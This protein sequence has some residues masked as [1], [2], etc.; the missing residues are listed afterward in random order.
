MLR[1][2]AG[3]EAEEHGG[4]EEEELEEERLLSDRSTG[5]SWVC[6]GLLGEWDWA[7]VCMCVW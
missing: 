7:K 4:E 3:E 1:D 2:E 6:V 5:S